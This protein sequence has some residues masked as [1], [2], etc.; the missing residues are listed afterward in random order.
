M[1][2]H[3]SII[4]NSSLAEY[5]S[6]SFLHLP[7][8][9][10]LPSCSVICLPWCHSFSRRSRWLLSHQPP[11]VLETPLQL[12]LPVQSS[13]TLTPLVESGR[14][15]RFVSSPTP[16]P[17]LPDQ[18][19]ADLMTGSNNNMTRLTTV[20]S[21]LDGTDESFSPYSWTCPEVDP[22]SVIYFYQVCIGVCCDPGIGN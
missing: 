17:Y 22:Y 2:P 8:Y 1:W 14:M 16:L 10:E 18:Y 9:L 13:G 15:S 11:L 3:F 4:S 12:A 20:V 5:R 21:G 19:V 7:E 6:P